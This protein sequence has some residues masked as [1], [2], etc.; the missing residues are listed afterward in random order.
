MVTQVEIPEQSP[1][2]IPV[3][4]QAAE[5]MQEPG[6]VRARA[7]DLIPKLPPTLSL[8]WEPRR[9]DPSRKFQ[10]LEGNLTCV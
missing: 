4:R 1:G 8:P 6:P 9:R 5:V 7:A 10:A 2:E 3:R